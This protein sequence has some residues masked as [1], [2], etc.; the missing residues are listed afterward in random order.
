MTCAL[1]LLFGA[2]PPIPVIPL[3]NAH[4]HNDYAHRRPLFDALSH[5]F[6]SVEADVFL[7]KGGLHVGHTWLDVWANPPGRT[8]EALYLAPL[9][10]RVRANG[11]HVHAAGKPFFLLIDIKTAGGPTYE[12]VH[13]ALAKYPD[14]FSGLKDGKFTRRAVTAVISGDVPRDAIRKQ[15]ERFAGIDGRPGDLDSAEPAHLMPWISAA[16]GP[17]FRWRGEGPMPAEERAKLAGMVKKAHAAGRMVRF[18]A[19]PEKV[20]VWKELRA[21]GV[22]LINTDRLGELRGFLLAGR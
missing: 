13:A 6:A 9:A 22:D 21:A 1:L 12:A 5:G 16:W 17:H 14:V 18:W 20:S 3:A 2:A 11:G 15:K 10:R 7:H 8:L 4:A 19:T